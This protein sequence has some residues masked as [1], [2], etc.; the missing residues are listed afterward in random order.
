MTDS[1]HVLWHDLEC[2]GYD[3]DLPLWREL[4][5]AAGGPV[6]D[7]GAGTGRVALHL[8]ARGAEVCALDA[9][10]ELLEALAR[11]AARLDLVVEPV[12][13]DAR[14]LDG[15]AGRG[16]ALVLVPMQTLQLLGGAGGRA[17]FLAGARRVLRDG[18][19]LAA[20]LADALEGYDETLDLEPPAP[21]MR[22][23]DGVVHA[24]RPVAVRDEGDGVVIVRVREV[25]S[26]GGELRSTVDE[27]R[28]DR[29]DAA[30]VA[31]EAAAHGFAAE[32]T[33]QVPATDEYVGSEVVVLRAV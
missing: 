29:V 4:A 11:R 3:D 25:V 12:V 7:V 10:G 21:D 24:S 20:A 30:T 14:E 31:A 32:P 9:D 6:L 16:F 1:E 22:E 19:I 18:G 27:T 17:R 5:S 8:A 15:L 13:A 23:V 2:G 26:P 33:R 28:L